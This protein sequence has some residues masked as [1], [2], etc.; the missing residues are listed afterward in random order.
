MAIRRRPRARH[1][2][3]TQGAVATASTV[4]APEEPARTLAALVHGRLRADVLRG[5]LRPGA[6]LRFDVLRRSYGVGLSPLREALSRLAANGLVAL[7]GQRGFQVA[8]VSLPDLR[9]IYDLRRRLEG[10]AL[11]ASIAQGDDGWE[12]EIVAAFHRLAKSYTR[13]Q[14]HPALHSDEW[15]RAHRAFHLALLN[16]CGSPWLLHLRNI[17]FDHSERYRQL[18]VAYG[19]PSRVSLREHRAVMDAALA[20]DAD[21]A[22]RLLEAHMRKTAEAAARGTDKFEAAGSARP[23]AQRASSRRRVRA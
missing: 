7:Q 19:Y 2:K 18:A 16:A 12:S 20:R 10:M 17:L 4:P 11:R 1:A 15:E 5:R 8:P 22:C 13:S 14:D 3:L 23:A 9:D 6:R 21:R